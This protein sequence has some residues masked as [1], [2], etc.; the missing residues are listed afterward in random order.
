MLPSRGQ[1]GKVLRDAVGKENGQN[2][3]VQSCVGTLCRQEDDL[4]IYCVGTGWGQ[5]TLMAINGTLSLGLMVSRRMVV[6][7]PPVECEREQ[8]NQGL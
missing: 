1:S 2:G 6:K 7:P 8:G 4:G 3:N 5:E